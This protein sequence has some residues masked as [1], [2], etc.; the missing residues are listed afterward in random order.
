M[1]PTD[2][3]IGKLVLYK[4][5]QLIAFHKPP[6]IPVAADKTGDKAMDQLG[7]IYCKSKLGL[8]HR[9]DRPASGVVLFARSENALANLN[10]QFREREVE[11]VYLAAV[12]QRPEQDEGTLTHYLSRNGRQNKTQVFSAPQK[13]AKQAELSYKYLESSD[14]YH[15]LEVKLHTGRHHQIRAQLA[16]IGSPIKGDVKYGFRRSNPDR[17]IHLHAWKLTFRH[18]VS[19]QQET[20]TAPLPQED[21]V[22]AAFRTE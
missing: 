6:R 4:N 18:P 21:P 12:K 7:E 13:G 11:K 14:H 10:A 15:L 20:I 16:A 17:S 3:D 2:F 19:N 9:I 22:W 8:V 5:N 1:P